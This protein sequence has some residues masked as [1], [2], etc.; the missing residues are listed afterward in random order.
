LYS[1][2]FNKSFVISVA[3]SI[4]THSLWSILIKASQV[5]MSMASKLSKITQNQRFANGRAI[6]RRTHRYE[7]IF[8]CRKLPLS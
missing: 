1:T 2:N 4:H 6:L 8:N 3:I 5:Q 7:C